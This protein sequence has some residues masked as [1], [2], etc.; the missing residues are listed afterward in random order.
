MK[1]L[2][3]KTVT[4]RPSPF[5]SFSFKT[6]LTFCSAFVLAACGS[7]SGSGTADEANNSS[8]AP[9]A[10]S[11][12]Q[13]SSDT[14]STSSEATGEPSRILV[15]QV[16]YAPQAA[17]VAVVP[18]GGAAE[19]VVIDTATQATVLQGELSAFSEW[20]PAGQVVAQAD[21]TEL[22]QP[23]TY[24]VRVEGVQDSDPFV[25][26]SQPYQALNASALKAYYYNRAGF[27]LDAEYAGEWARDA[28]HADTE[29]LVHASAASDQRPEGTVISAPKGWYDAGDYGKYVVNS[30]I[31]TYTL[32]AALEHF[33][34][35]YTAND[36]GIPESG[37][38]TPDILEEVMWNLE[39]M[40][41]M[42][43]PNDG[44]VYHKLTTKN[45]S[46]AVMPSEAT[47]TRY[48]VQK[49]TAATLNFAAV[50]AAASRVVAEY[51]DVYSG[52]S[53]EMLSAAQSAW[54]WAEANPDIAYQQPADVS[55][56]AYDD[57]T[58]NDEF[59]W[60]AAEL[61]ISTGN[62]DYYQT[63]N[64][65]EQSISNPAWAHTGALAWVSLAH[66]RANLTEA[67]DVS[68]IE[69]GVQQF[70]QELVADSEA[71]AYGVAL[72]HGDFYWGS[73]G[74]ALNKAMMLLQGY[75]LSGD[76]QQL[77][78]AQALFDYILG[79]NPTEYS[80][81]TGFG[82]RPPMHIHH[83]QSEA[84]SVVEPVP[85][86][87]A[88]GPNTAAHNDCGA[89]QYPAGE[90][91]IARA[92]LDHWCSYST[93]EVTINW[94]APLVYVSGALESIYGRE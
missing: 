20:T 69:S 54:Q 63:L 55:T 31:S 71:S 52:L 78:A 92:Y 19:F 17:K 81:V 76:A 10:S 62:D 33:G 79:L 51:E 8:P 5:T 35:F 30:G 50:M 26:A 16:G 18:E 6:V 67:A 39:W 94:N 73:N 68:L 1:L 38:S 84:D 22:A 59:A 32:L 91:A 44:G 61:Y 89:D 56:G 25:V 28:G 37:N 64:L 40:L 75:R 27:A 15:N 82:E 83:R 45:F 11:S 53:D 36:T 90:E 12:N 60:A 72:L 46:G 48:V 87:V 29:V 57:D 34:D 74:G 47:D 43:D 93:N 41:D 70:A 2:T 21:F 3:N 80:Y 88:G 23:G 77:K 13:A 14:A 9:T 86:F 58:F 65:T 4:N 49:T 66:H 7:N 42:Q 85:G 24:V